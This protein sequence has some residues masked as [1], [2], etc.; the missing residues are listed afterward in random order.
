MAPPVDEPLNSPA[1]RVIELLAP[2]PGRAEFAFRLALI[3]ALTL[4]VVEIYQDPSPALTAYVA[5]FLIKPDR[6]G[7]ILVAIVLGLLITLI[8]AMLMLVT[9][10][11]LD[12]PLW[13]FT[14]IALISFGLLFAASASKLKEI[15]GIIALI[16]GYGLDIL[17][18]AQIGELATRA[19][20]YAWLF[21]TIPA[22]V[23]IVVNL[24]I[25]PPPRRLAERTLAYR[26]RLAAAVLR[27]PEAKERAA[28]V[29][30]L[31][32]GTGEIP[33]WLKLA[34]VERTAD[35]ADLAPLAQAARSTS[36]LFSLVDVIVR[37]E[38]VN[39]ATTSRR[40]LAPCLEEMARIL[41]RGGYPVDIDFEPDLA[42]DASAVTAAAFTTIREILARFA[43]APAPVPKPTT[44]AKSG[45]FVPDAFTNPLHVQYALKATAAAM[46]CYVTYSLLDWPGI[47][48]CFI[49]VYIVSLGTTAETVEKMTLRILGCLIG[50]ALGIAA[51]AFVMPGVTSIGVLMAIIAAAAFI[52]GWIAAGSPR[53]SY[54]GYQLAFAFFLCVVQG[55]GPEFDMTIA[56]DRVIGIIFGNLVVAL[57]F[58]QLWPVTVAKRIDPSI[59][60]VLRKLASLTRERVSWKRLGLVAETQAAI[61][62]V[63][64]D[65][66]LSGYEP[67]SIR[68]ARDWIR[69]RER[70]LAAI[71]ASL[72]PL[73]LSTRPD[74]RAT[75]DIA[76]RL[77]H[78]ADAFEKRRPVHEGPQPQTG[79]DKPDLLGTSLAR[80]EQ[81]IACVNEDPLDREAKYA[82]A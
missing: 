43:V 30:A 16:A 19:L 22:G 72:G 4:L 59:A 47:H 49:T 21:V 11:V 57:I 48:T 36:A 35:P 69:C 52:S 17:G 64:Q 1:R 73:L 13:R 81:A 77:G 3:C 23:S 37:T 58:T 24:L 6:T 65:V 80:I 2:F 82:P 41:D 8:I 32:E 29:E 9:M 7:S 50:A 45:F 28:F 31:H 78:L 34:G 76:D 44:E 71:D 56:R 70:I 25:G 46:I 53:V 14:A 18:Q 15:G 75:D 42:P 33:G 38:D 27:D 26:L 60:A 74:R 40:R 39:A 63:D 5:F 51:I 54:V 68:P 61:G 79:G 55:P 20:L 67:Q 10:L 66:E 12:V 62:A